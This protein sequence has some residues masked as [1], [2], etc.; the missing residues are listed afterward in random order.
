MTIALVSE[1][2]DRYGKKDKKNKI[3][4][5]ITAVNNNTDNFANYYTKT[6]LQTSGQS[7]VHWDNITNKP[8]TYPPSSHSDHPSI[9][10]GGTTVITDTRVLQ[11]VT[12]DASIITSGV[13]ALARIP[14]IPYTKLDTLDTPSDGEVLTYDAGNDSMEWTPIPS[15][16]DEKVKADS[17][18]STAGY[19]ADKVDNSTI[20]VNTSNHYLYVLDSPKWGGYSRGDAQTIGGNITIGGTLKVSGNN[21]IDSAG[22]TIF[23]LG[24]P[25]TLYKTLKPSADGS[26]ELGTWSSYRWKSV[27]TVRVKTNYINP[28]I[29]T[30]VYIFYNSPNAPSR[31]IILGRKNATSSETTKDSPRLVFRGSYWDSGAGTAKDYDA[32]IFLDMIGQPSGYIR[33]YIGGG[34]RFN[35]FSNGDIKCFGDLTVGGNDIKDSGGSVRITIGGTYTRIRTNSGYVDLGPQNTSYCHFNTDR[36]QFYFNKQ[37][38]VNGNIRRYGN[39]SELPL[40]G[41]QGGFDYGASMWLR[42]KNYGDTA[43]KGAARI[44]L[45]YDSDIGN[46]PHFDIY[47]RD[48]KN[49]TWTEIADIDMNGN[50]WIKGDFQVKGNDVKDSGGTTRI[51]LGS[52]TKITAPTIQ[53]M[54]DGSTQLGKLYD[55]SGKR[56]AEFNVLSFSIKYGGAVYIN[57]RN[58]TSGYEP[59]YY[60]QNAPYGKY[61][62][63]VFDTTSYYRDEWYFYVSGSYSKKFHFD[64]TGKAWAATGWTSCLTDIP[65]EKDPYGKTLRQLRQIIRNEHTKPKGPQEINDKLFESKPDSLD[66][67]IKSYRI[68]AEYEEMY[69]KNI[70]LLAIANAKILDFLL[71]LLIKKGVLSDSDLDYM[72]GG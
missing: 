62:K 71:D 20:A 50:M 8:S 29:D 32:M 5:I 24:N 11:N 69:A 28:D 37:I 1:W 46:S 34:E 51:T 54:K 43:T 35:I 21:I 57:V 61:L 2:W 39:S 6:E 23:V 47:V 30:D 9:S 60:I 27:N 3:N 44:H 53:F 25:T 59:A 52:T 10:I 67:N 36:G 40:Y 49:A 63:K 19:L 55:D 64:S 38:I 33:F 22:N 17:N 13:F 58:E 4:E 66:K 7:S 15:S 26:I 48:V 41:A 16:V 14:K 12:A 72:M 65:P 42:S 56:R 70:S 18:D 68:K 45:C 31:K